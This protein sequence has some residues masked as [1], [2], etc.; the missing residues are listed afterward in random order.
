MQAGASRISSERWQLAARLVYLAVIGVATL[1]SIRWDFDSSSVSRRLA[2]LLNPSVSARDAVDAIRNV[3]LFA[4]WGLVW[5]LTARSPSR[6][7]AL[8]AACLTGAVISIGVEFLQLF[9]WTRTPSALDVATNTTGALLGGLGL[10]AA[11]RILAVQG[12]RRSLLGIPA[13]VFAA[14][15][16]AAVLGEALIPLFRQDPLPGVYGGPVARFT[17]AAGRFEWGSLYAVPWMDLM[18][19]MP[20]GLMAVAALAERGLPIGRAAVWVA[21]AGGLLM[22]GTEIAHAALGLPIEVGAILLHGAAVAIGAVLAIPA[23]PALERRWQGSERA[24][25]VMAAYAVLL[26]V[27][28]LRPYIPETDLGEIR[29]ELLSEWYVPLRLLSMRGDVFSAVDVLIG[30]L[31]YMPLGALLSVWPLGGRIL[32]GLLPALLLAAAAELA[33]VLVVGRT[34]DITDILVHSAG[35]AAG[36]ALLRRGGFNSRVPAPHRSMP[37]GTQFIRRP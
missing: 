2:R 15:Y 27:W 7:R 6:T 23:L 19:F 36:W 30:F 9:S 22:A 4:G 20:A 31:L 16:G 13:L 37:R 10:L 8:I 24:R 28:A 33:Q 1:S 5:V 3:L 25:A 14:C 18:L 26:L 34:L 11:E 12:S 29:S 35:A 32:R 21:A 17:A